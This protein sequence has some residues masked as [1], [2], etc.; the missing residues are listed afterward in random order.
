MTLGQ[1]DC[2][3]CHVVWL[4]PDWAVMLFQVAART[5]IGV[6]RRT[7][8]MSR[9]CSKRKSRF[10]SLWG[11]DT[12]SKK[13][14]KPHPSINQVCKLFPVSKWS[15]ELPWPQRSPFF[16]RHLSS[17]ILLE[18]WPLDPLFVPAGL[19]WWW[20]ASEKAFRWHICWSCQ[21]TD[22]K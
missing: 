20:R 13:K 14:T 8:A 17:T 9:S 5:E 3:L 19:C 21:G 4:S 6:R 15:I 12:T 1:R 16:L 7:Q 2:C 18:L 22:S 11:L 10:S